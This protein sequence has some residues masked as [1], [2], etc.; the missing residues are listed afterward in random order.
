[1]EIGFLSLELCTPGSRLWPPAWPAMLTYSGRISV[2]MSHAFDLRGLLQN[3]LSSYL[4]RFNWLRQFLELSSRSVP[5]KL[6]RNQRNLKNFWK[7][8]RNLKK[9]FILKNCH[10]SIGH[11]GD[12]RWVNGVDSWVERK[13][14]ILGK[15]N[16]KISLSGYPWKSI[17]LSFDLAIC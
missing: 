1:M 6:S 16:R 12:F 14:Q 11:P 10:S 13:P 2:S 5:N 15:E 7:I 4:K 9:L 8:F 3:L 17:F